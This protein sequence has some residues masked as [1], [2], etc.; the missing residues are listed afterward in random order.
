ML[1]VTHSGPVFTAV[2]YYERALL[3]LRA[4]AVRYRIEYR[5]KC[6][7][8]AIMGHVVRRQE[9]EP[10]KQSSLLAIGDDDPK[11]LMVVSDDA[12]VLQVLEVGKTGTPRFYDLN[13]HLV[14]G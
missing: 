11:V 1:D 2:G 10:A 4:L 7:G 12:S 8:C 14:A 5:G 3:G 6:T 13:R 9:D